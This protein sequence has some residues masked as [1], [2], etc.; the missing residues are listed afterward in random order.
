MASYQIDETAP[1]RAFNGHT[2]VA[3]I[4]T[5]DREGATPFK[6]SA[7][8][9]CTDTCSACAGGDQKEWFAGEEW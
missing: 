4:Y 3:P 5:T 9:Y 1:Y 6:I 7:Y 2:M 8:A